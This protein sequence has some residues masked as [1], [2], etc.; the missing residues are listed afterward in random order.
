MT[1]ASPTPPEPPRPK[2]ITSTYQSAQITP[3][4]FRPHAP[5]GVI[6]ET[7]GVNPDPPA[8]RQVAPDISP[9]VPYEG[10]SPTGYDPYT[11]GTF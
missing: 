5:G 10:D 4:T 1:G 7:V 11:M 6:T 2:H 9:T 3:A 8:N